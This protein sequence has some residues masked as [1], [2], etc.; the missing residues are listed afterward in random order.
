MPV[1]RISGSTI[2]EPDSSYSYLTFL[3]SLDQVATETI[4]VPWQV[5]DGTATGQADIY[6]GGSYSSGTAY[7]YAGRSQVEVRMRAFGDLAAEADESV[8]M[9]IFQPIN[10]ELENGA[11]SQQAVGWINDDDG[12]L[13]PTSLFVS[14]PRVLEGGRAVFD[15][16]L[17]R[18]AT[19]TLNI[20][21]TLDGTAEAGNDYLDIS[22]RVRFFAGQDQTSLVVN[23]KNDRV[24]ESLEQ[25]DLKL[26]LPNSI[27]EVT[28]GQA[29]IIDEDG[30]LDEP[31]V[32][33]AGTSIEESDSSYRNLTFTVML[34][35]PSSETV[36]VPWSM[37]PALAEGTS[38]RYSG[39]SY[40]AGT[41]YF[42]PG[43][44]IER[45]N[46]RALGDTEAETDESVVVKIGTPNNAQL[47]GGVKFV[48]ATGWIRDDDGTTKPLAMQVSNP[49]I[50]ELNGEGVTANFLVELSAPAPRDLSINWRT[51]AGSAKGGHDFK[52]TNGTLEIEKGQ[53]IGSIGVEVKG[54]TATEIS[55]TFSLQFFLPPDIAAARGGTAT[56]LDN[57]EGTPEIVYGNNNDN[58]FRG[59]D[60]IQRFFG[61]DGDDR[62]FGGG[63][64]DRLLGG[65]GKDEL[66]GGTGSDLLKGQ[67]GND[68]MKGQAGGD[69]LRGGGGK[70]K[71][72][73]GSGNDRLFGNGGNDRLEGQGGSD[74]LVGSN[75]KDRLFGGNGNDLLEGGRG[76]DVLAGDRG[77][78]TF[79]FDKASGRDLVTDFRNGKDTFEIESGANRFRDLDI[80]RNDGDVY[81]EFA[82]TTI[83][84]EDTQ[85][86]QIGATDFFFT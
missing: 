78:D 72:Y 2:T 22:G 39:G 36:T 71:A 14:S 56:I 37:S 57:D 20:P 30:R 77:K 21:F 33:V 10:A 5:I 76:R 32:L 1:A 69:V 17:S 4:R 50:A 80:S 73:G 25:I 49:E 82:N 3:I 63:G 58:T 55:E 41:L 44:M 79:V 16:K 29:T 65:N 75:G 42:S 60:Y 19:E 24:A 18:P 70:D 48:E 52:K 85:L 61:R 9:E 43:E 15:L 45:I 83:V 62:L 6:S 64:D 7:I 31:Y 54:D 86:Q 68:V 26:N 67:G 66:I 23:V 13:R 51:V 35:E 11:I 47:P 8:V 40:D 59:N 28:G 74:T 38:D 46:V 27:A 12:T 81:V 53:S 34:T 84:I